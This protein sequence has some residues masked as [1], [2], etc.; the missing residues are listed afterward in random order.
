MGSMDIPNSACVLCNMKVELGLYLFLRCLI[1]RAIWFAAYWGFKSDQL[2]ST[3]D[4]I[5]L[6]L[7]PPTGLCQAQDSWL[8]SLNMAFTLEEIWH[9]RNAV[10]HLKGSVDLQA[11]IDKI[12]A[13][14]KEC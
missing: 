5:K 8:V 10:L 6:I 2:G 4:I 7:D 12:G 11:S 14:L 3:N 1:S 9:N 13:R